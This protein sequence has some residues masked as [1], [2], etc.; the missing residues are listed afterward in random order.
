[1]LSNWTEATSSTGGTG[2]LTLAATGGAA[3]PGDVFPLANQLVQYSIVEYADTTRSTIAQAESGW[4]L[5]GAGGTLNR[6]S[7]Q[8]TWVGSSTRSYANSGE[9]VPL[10]FT[11]DPL[12]LRISITA[13]AE[14]GPAAYPG[15]GAF[16]AP[17]VFAANYFAA[18]PSNSNTTAGRLYAVPVF[19]PFS[20]PTASAGVYVGTAPASGTATMNVAIAQCSPTT[21]NPHMILWA[22]NDVPISAG[23]MN[24]A[25][26]G[27]FFA[28]GWY[29]F[30]FGT[31][32]AVSVGMTA[33]LIA[34]P[35]GVSGSGGFK[36]RYA[37]KGLTVMTAGE[38][39]YGSGAWSTIPNANGPMPY[40]KL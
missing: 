23:G 32:E 8:A 4:G 3:L 14:G 30:L 26:C 1:M 24:L 2:P 6:A 13:T 20:R 16:G 10:S 34:G 31:N 39:A 33:D 17:A 21:S 22:A 15:A 35:A 5:L 9:L 7:V 11:S 36:S 40:F 25:T 27:Q 29:W 28:P 19:L 18:Q 38:T 12:K 37:Y